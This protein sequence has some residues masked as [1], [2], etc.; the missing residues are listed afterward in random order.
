M[1]ILRDDKVEGLVGFIR[2]RA[3]RVAGTIWAH[4]R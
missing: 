4:G 2:L 1:F 3:S